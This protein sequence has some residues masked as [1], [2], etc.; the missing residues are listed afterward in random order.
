VAREGA[1]ARHLVGALVATHVHVCASHQRAQQWH[2]AVP[3]YIKQNKWRATSAASSAAFIAAAKRK[4][5]KARRIIIARRR[6]ALA[7]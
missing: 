4:A 2:M 3:R 6:I 5:H 1:S 7:S